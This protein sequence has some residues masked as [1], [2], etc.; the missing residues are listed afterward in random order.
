M[1]FFF[2][3]L[4]AFWSLDFALW[5]TCQQFSFSDHQCL[6]FS[7][8]CTLFTRMGSDLTR[9]WSGLEIQVRI[10]GRSF[11]HSPLNPYGSAQRFPEKR[12][13]CIR[14]FTLEIQNISNYCFDFSIFCSKYFCKYEFFHFLVITHEAWGKFYEF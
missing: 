6:S 5:K 7:N 3:F 1:F 2:L 4:P 13:C 14:I 10:F 11:F 12:Q 9:K 8:Y